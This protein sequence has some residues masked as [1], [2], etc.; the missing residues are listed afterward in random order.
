[1]KVKLKGKTRHGKNRVNQ[2][3]EWW[4]VSAERDNSF[5]LESIDC[6]CPTCEKWG[7]DGRAVDKK[8]DTNFNIVNIMKGDKLV[9]S[10]K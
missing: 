1:M 5:W 9:F 4:V 3:G 7:Q 8:N 6:E 2:H 10:N